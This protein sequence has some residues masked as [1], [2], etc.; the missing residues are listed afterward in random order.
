MTTDPSRVI[1]CTGE[2]SCHS[3]RMPQVHHRDFP[4]I[5][6]E[7]P[8]DAAAASNLI[9]QLTLALDYVPDHRRREIMQRAIA[10]VEAYV[11]Q[12]IQE[13]QPLTRTAHDTTACETG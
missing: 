1:P 13:D 4:E 8:S 9:L 3:I 5:R 11:E 2:C 10:D 6:G 12:G 7:G